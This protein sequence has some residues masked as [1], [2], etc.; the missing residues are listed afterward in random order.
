MG[1]ATEHRNRMYS[2]IEN[3]QQSGLSQ[4]VFCGQHQ[5]AAHQFYYWYKCYRTKNDVSIAGVSQDFIELPTQEPSPEAAIEILLAC[6]HRIKFH[7]PVA[8][9]FIKSIIS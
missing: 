7:Q 9:S 8:A 1:A 2:F 4:K 3:W 6:G 5:I